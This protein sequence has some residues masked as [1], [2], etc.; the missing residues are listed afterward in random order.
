MIITTLCKYASH[1][2]NFLCLSVAQLQL[3]CYCSY[4]T[5]TFAV[6]WLCFVDNTEVSS[7]THHLRPTKLCSVNIW[8][9]SLVHYQSITC[10]CSSC[11]FTRISC[12]LFFYD[13]VCNLQKINIISGKQ[14]LLFNVSD[15]VSTHMQVSMDTRVASFTSNVA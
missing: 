8:I 10:D 5:A 4:S 11:Y 7:S 6:I 3:L 13:C 12:V 9:F 2:C 14:L 1:Y 15:G